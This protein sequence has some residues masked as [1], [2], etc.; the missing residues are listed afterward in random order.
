MNKKNPVPTALANVANMMID[1]MRKL[2]AGELNAATAQAMALCGKQVIDAH[3][4][5][6]KT[7]LALKAL[8]D[9]G[10]INDQLQY[11]EP[12]VS[13]DTE[14]AYNKATI[15]DRAERDYFRS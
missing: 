13:P 12:N 10:I 1:A 6:L 5:E 15:D 14:K 2:E 9:G 8:Q 11:L 4:T 3:N 7:V